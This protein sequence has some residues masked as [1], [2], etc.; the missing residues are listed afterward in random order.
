MQGTSR[1]IVTGERTCGGAAGRGLLFLFLHLPD[2]GCNFSLQL[3]SLRGKSLGYLFSGFKQCVTLMLDL[4]QASL[5]P[6]IGNNI[7][8]T[9]SVLAQQ[10]V[11]APLSIQF[12]TFRFVPGQPE[13]CWHS[14]GR[15]LSFGYWCLPVACTMMRDAELL[16]PPNRCLIKAHPPHLR[17]VDH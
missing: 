11:V 17:L 7:E 3:G 1:A 6:D 8:I 5:Q 10:R 9:R 2:K 13:Q 4:M 15:P 14:V 16:V 12:F